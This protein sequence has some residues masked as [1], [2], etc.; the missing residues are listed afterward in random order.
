M[1]FDR[2]VDHRGMDFTLV[3]DGRSFPINKRMLLDIFEIHPSLFDESSYQVQ[4]AVGVEDFAA[5]VTYLNSKQLSV[6]TPANAKSLCLLSEEFGIPDLASHCSELIPDLENHSPPLNSV[7][8]ELTTNILS[9]MT[10]F[11]S[12][13]RDFPVCFSSSVFSHL[14]HCEC[15]ILKMRGEFVDR[16]SLMRDTIPREIA[17]L[18]SRLQTDLSLLKSKCD[19]FRLAI[20]EIHAAPRFFPVTDEEHLNGIIAYLTDKHGGN[21]HEKEIVVMTSKSGRGANNLVD[22]KSD[23]DFKSDDA[24]DQWVSWEFRECLVCP[25]QHNAVFH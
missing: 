11:E 19:Q 7:V 23:Q 14:E 25:T 17:N 10:Q 2:T 6:T 22:L 1:F 20:D 16:L 24:A 9:Q 8:A 3:L 5:F 12:F 13:R 4:S 15:G 18:E 21:L